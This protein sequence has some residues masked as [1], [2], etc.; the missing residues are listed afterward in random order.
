MWIDVCVYACTDIYT[1][2]DIYTHPFFAVAFV[3]LKEWAIQI[4]HSVYIGLCVP[5]DGAVVALAVVQT[6]RH[7][8]RFEKLVVAVH[9][10]CTVAAV[11]IKILAIILLVALAIT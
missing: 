9:H 1:S 10:L 5:T 3:V 2:V 11:E 4:W 8:V 7:V 6:S